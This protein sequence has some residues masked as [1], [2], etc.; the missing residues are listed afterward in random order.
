MIRTN[1]TT[2]SASGWRVQANFKEDKMNKKSKNFMAMVILLIFHLVFFSCNGADP[3]GEKKPDSGIDPESGNETD[4]GNEL[5][6]EIWPIDMALIP[7]GTFIMGS[8]ITEPN[9]SSDEAQHSVTLSGFS[10]GKYLVTQ[11]QWVTVMG[12]FEDRTVSAWGKGD[13]YPIYYVS[14]YDVIVF[15]NKLSIKEKLDPVYSINGSANPAD[16]GTVPASDDDPNITTWNAAV[17]D[18]NKNGY[19]LPT[20]AEWEYACR[21]DYPDKATETKTKPFGIGD[22]TKMISGMANF[23]VEYPYD[24]NHSP[25]GDY[26]DENAAGYVYKTTEVGSYEANNYGL[27]DMCGNLFEWCWDWYKADIKADNT[28][29]AGA[30]TGSKRVQ[31]GGYWFSDGKYLRSAFRFFADPEDRYRGIGFRLVR[32]KEEN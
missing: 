1:G 11:A 15:C 16:W 8:P 27:Y 31:R 19:R 22:G 29:P 32:S 9:R 28:N 12:A 26:D 2:G 17:M 10:M 20:E 30:V 13:N 4:S 14:W 23:R 18:R 6:N 5:V 21:G 25:A 24:L 3:V 7:A